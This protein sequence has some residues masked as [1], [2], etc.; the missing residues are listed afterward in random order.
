METLKLKEAIF[1]TLGQ[2]NIPTQVINRLYTKDL[3][4]QACSIDW[5]NFLLNRNGTQWKFLKENISAI[6]W[7][8]HGNFNPLQ[9]RN[10]LLANYASLDDD[11]ENNFYLLLFR[12]L[13]H[14]RNISLQDVQ[15][16]E[17]E[18]VTIFPVHNL[19]NLALRQYLTTILLTADEYYSPCAEQIIMQQRTT[20]WLEN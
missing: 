1:L 8:N 16:A 18:L 19:E 20:F 6:P 15:K 14:D 3:E 7:P 4:H 9:L 17:N 10:E 13:N 11:N 2:I 5:K 12:Y